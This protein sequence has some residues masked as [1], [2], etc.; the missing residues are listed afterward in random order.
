MSQHYARWPG[1]TFQ[2]LRCSSRNKKIYNSNEAM[3]D[4][5]TL[6][7]ETNER[8][9]GS[10]RT[11]LRGMIKI[12]NKSTFQLE[13]GS[14]IGRNGICKPLSCLDSG[15]SMWL[16]LIPRTESYVLRPLFP[17]HES[18]GIE[19]R[20]YWSEPLNFGQVQDSHSIIRKIKILDR[21]GD[22][23]VLNMKVSGE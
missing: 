1:F 20:L 8:F 18:A 21:I 7:V 6:V 10:W 22:S 19:S 14:Q 9:C 15:Q 2:F 4:M 12:V 5:P 23:V 3:E 16:P 11:T 17:E 13:F